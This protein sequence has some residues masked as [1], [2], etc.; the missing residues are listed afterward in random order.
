M[1][2]R[3]GRAQNAG[4]I[5]PV[6][7]PPDVRVTG[8]LPTSLTTF[9]GRARE[10]D[11]LRSLFRDGKRLVTLVDIGGIGKTRLAMELGSGADHPLSPL[12]PV[13][14][15]VTSRRTRH[16]GPSRTPT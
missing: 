14:R 11:Q 3:M 1:I 10:L 12:C 16:P 4:R 6:D 9:V 2:V 5:S 8:A 15:P 7:T 13:F